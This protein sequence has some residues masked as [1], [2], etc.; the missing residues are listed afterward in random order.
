MYAD[1]DARAGVLEP[2]GIVE[3]KMRRDKI[4]KLM[5]R[6]DSTYASLK[7]DSNDTSKTPEQRATAS[8]ALASRETFLQPTYQQIALLYADLHEYATFCLIIK[9]PFFC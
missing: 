3:I 5:E 1:V 9:P 6:L 7:R 4:V 2:E 8:S